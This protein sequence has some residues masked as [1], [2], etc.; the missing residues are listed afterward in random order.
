MKHRVG[1]LV[2]FVC[3]VVVIGA[4]VGCGVDSPN[5][6]DDDDDMRHQIEEEFG[7]LTDD[8]IEGFE[9]ELEAQYRHLRSTYER[10]DEART[11]ANEGDHDAHRLH[12]K[13]KRRHRTLARLHEDRLWL[14]A[15]DNQAS[16]ADDR[17]LAE[18]HRAAAKWHQDRYRDDG[19]G[20][21]D[22]DTDLEALRDHLEDGP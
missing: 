2:L 19:T 7:A 20:V 14:Y 16:P 21:E 9:S 17:G 3:M 6:S 4:G 13:L 22:Q 5:R 8:Q 10:Y 12:R 1:V 11:A 18:S 15:R